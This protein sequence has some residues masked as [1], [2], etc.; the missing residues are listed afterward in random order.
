MYKSKQQSLIASSS[1]EAEFIAASQAIKELSWLISLLSEL[2]INTSKF[3]YID[4]QAAIHLIKN[5]EFNQR[6]KHIDIK[7][8]II[9]EKFKE[10]LFELYYVPTDLQ[11]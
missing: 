10:K 5:C 3:L 4:N 7:F 9:K 8:K 1:T 2:E 6:T 11:K